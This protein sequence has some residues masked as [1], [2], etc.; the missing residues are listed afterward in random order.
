M[1]VFGSRAVVSQKLA[2]DS[3]DEG[4]RTPALGAVRQKSAARPAVVASV[5]EAESARHRNQMNQRIGGPGNR[6]IGV[7]HCLRRRRLNAGSPAASPKATDVYCEPRRILRTYVSVS[8]RANGT[9]KLHRID[10]SSAL[11]HGLLN[12]LSCES[13][14]LSTTVMPCSSTTSRRHRTGRVP[15]C[16]KHR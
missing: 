13:I 10:A 7:S 5:H 8:G 2:I 12:S 14:A 1:V 6:H 16:T 9:P 3:K 4:F 15:R 11:H